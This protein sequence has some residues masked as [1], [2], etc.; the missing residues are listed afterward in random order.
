LTIL[1]D[2]REKENT[3]ILELFDKAKIVHKKKALKY[4]DYSFMIPK[5]E[6]LNIPRDMYFDKQ[7]VIERKGSLEE[8]S[9]N[10]TNSRDRFEKELS[11][12]PA[13]KALVIE[14]ADYEK[15]IKG[16]YNTQYNKK[17]FF[18][19]LHKF[20]FKYNIPFVFMPDSKYTG[21]FIRGYFEQYLRNY[22]H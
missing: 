18:A 3:H 4:G 21:V 12:A 5:N 9:S 13:N 2:T 22:L 20:W 17:S 14:N 10:L 19:S 1:V 6:V 7:I 8:L 15:L 11:L 16:D